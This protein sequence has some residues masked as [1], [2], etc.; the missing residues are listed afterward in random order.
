MFFPRAQSLGRAKRRRSGRTMRRLRKLLEFP[1]LLSPLFFPLQE[2]QSATSVAVLKR[3]PDRK[4]DEVAMEIP[5]RKN[6]LVSR[7][8]VLVVAVI[9]TKRLSGPVIC[10]VVVKSAVRLVPA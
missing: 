8:R 6:I 2:A 5:G 10:N 4:C 1:S 9:A 7:G 3:V